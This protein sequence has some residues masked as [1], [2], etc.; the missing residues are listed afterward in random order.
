[1]SKKKLDVPVAVTKA[2]WEEYANIVLESFTDELDGCITGLHL[3]HPI[4]KK[5]APIVQKMRDFNFDFNS[6]ATVKSNDDLIKLLN[7][8][9]KTIIDNEGFSEM[10]DGFTQAKKIIENFYK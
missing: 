5:V 10:A 4:M 6:A 7:Q 8:I 1:M 3:G 2:I 9:L